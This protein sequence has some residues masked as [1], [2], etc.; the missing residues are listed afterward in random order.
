MSVEP[1]LLASW[2]EDYWLS[3]NKPESLTINADKVQEIIDALR[4]CD[5]DRMM[6]VVV[7]DLPRKKL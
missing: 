3:W 1:K 5:D 2:L 4:Q 6:G 7:L